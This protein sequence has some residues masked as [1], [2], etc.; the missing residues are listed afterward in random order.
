MSDFNPIIPPEDNK[1]EI[2]ID[3]NQSSTPRIPAKV[4]K[5]PLSINNLVSTT[6]MHIIEDEKC[7]LE[8][9]LITRELNALIDKMSVKELIEYYKAKLKEREFH[10]DSIFKA[11]N[12]SI[13]TEYAKHLLTGTDKDDRSIKNI[14]SKSRITALAN[15]LKQHSKD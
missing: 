14:T 15:L 6:K 11:F 13:K 4:E 3:T 7:R 5:D 9:E 1:P 8:I 2:I 12:F 10:S